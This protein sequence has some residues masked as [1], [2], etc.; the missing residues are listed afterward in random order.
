[1]RLHWMP[2]SGRCTRLGLVFF[3]LAV[4][5]C[6]QTAS[7]MSI[8]E[9][10][11]RERSNGKQGADF[12]LYYL[13]GVMEASLHAE[14]SAVRAGASPRICLQGRP[15]EPSMAV[16]IYRAELRRNADLYEADMPVSM[17]MSN[18]LATIYAC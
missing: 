3:F 8:R 9:L 4:S 12:G 13:V 5:A 18:A 7:A 1:M 11:A 14:A 16:S 17:V 6:L 2:A 15:L 10:R